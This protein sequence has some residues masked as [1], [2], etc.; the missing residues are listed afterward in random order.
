MAVEKTKDKTNLEIN[1]QN[2]EIL[3]NP[4][5]KTKVGVDKSDERVLIKNEEL[6]KDENKKIDPIAK[7]LISLGC[8]LASI[9]LGITLGIAIV[10]IPTA[11]NITHKYFSALGSGNKAHVQTL[12]DS[13]SSNMDM[14]LPPD[15]AFES[16][17][18][19][20]SNINIVDTKIDGDN[21]TVDAKVSVKDMGE[22]TF[23]ITLKK[24]G[25][26]LLFFPNWK[27][28]NLQASGSAS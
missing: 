27:I 19:I 11:T 6:L 17:K 7:L 26:Y 28:E 12:I 18:N 21:A 8:G 15:E 2:N 1:T 5:A 13:S 16:L 20:F 25:N 3:I 4:E 10:N 24:E 23:T 14:I 22:N 9:G